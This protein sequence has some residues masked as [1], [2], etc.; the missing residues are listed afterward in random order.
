MPAKTRL[1]WCYFFPPKT[2]QSFLVNFP[3][4]YAIFIY[5]GR[6]ISPERLRRY[7]L[8]KDL[9]WTCTVHTRMWRQLWGKRSRLS[10]H[11]TYTCSQLF[12]LHRGMFRTNEQKQY[13]TTTSYSSPRSPRLLLASIPSFSTGASAISSLSKQR[14]TWYIYTLKHCPGAIW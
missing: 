3:C 5:L 13:N 9:P 6:K 10:S 8:R 12:S 14:V 2:S 4:N 7:T 1:S 11:S